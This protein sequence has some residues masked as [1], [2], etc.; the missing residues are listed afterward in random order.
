MKAY[1]I[2]CVTNIPTPYRNKLYNLMQDIFPKKGLEFEVLYMAKKEPNRKWK[3]DYSEITYNYKIFKGLHPAIGN[4]YAHFNPGLFTHLL[5]NPADLIIVGGMGCPSHWLTPFIIRKSKKKILSIES[6]LESVKV[7]NGLGAWLKRLI[8]KQYQA[9]QVTGPRSIEYLRY[10]NPQINGPYFILPNII[11]EQKFKFEVSRLKKQR[12]VFRDNYGINPETQLWICP[13]RL[14]KF[15]GLHIFLPLLKDLRGIKLLIVGE[16]S[17]R[18]N[19]QQLINKYKL[20]VKLVGFKQEKEMLNLYAAA[21]L[22]VLPSLSDPSP[23]SPIEAIAGGLPVLVSNKIG[24]F[25]DVFDG[26]NGWAINM[27]NDRSISHKIVQEI[28]KSNQNT[29]KAKG[30]NSLS[31]YD[32]NFDSNSLITSYADN[33]LAFLER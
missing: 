14:E 17:Q 24:N 32:K 26:K 33:L 11:D 22:F 5:K 28:S 19:L 16:G 1:K 12:F 10:F 27:D 3:I 31:L 23:L 6:N 30:S 29:L 15:K 9:F 13:A 18:E 20:P 4:M 2:I 21:D 25:N 8:I 7:T